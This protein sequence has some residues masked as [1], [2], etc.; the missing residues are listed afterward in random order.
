VAVFVGV[1]G[2]G[3]FGVQLAAA[4]GAHTVALDVDPAR[5]AALRAHGAELAI[6]VRGRAGKDVR[7]EIAA[8]AASVSA[9]KTRWKIFETSGTV[10]GQD[11]AFALLN[12][13]AYLGVVGF[14]ME[15]VSVRLSNLMAFDA[16]AEGAWGCLPELYPSALELI[17]AGKVRI[18]P[19]VERRPLSTIDAVFAAL[20]RHEFT[21][22]PVL[23]PDL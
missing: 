3:G 7:K 23:V 11:L 15:P 9:P 6:D 20:V 5:L 19:F 4:L 12:H 13:G 10:P 16:R 21:R 2:V 17:L 22:R 14:T 18:A 1:G 8:F